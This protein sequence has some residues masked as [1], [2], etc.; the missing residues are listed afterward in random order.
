[1]P[2][3]YNETRIF[4]AATM[5]TLTDRPV[6]AFATWG[7]WIVATGTVRELRSIFPAAEVHDFGNSVVVPGFNDAHQHPTMMAEH[8]LDVDLSPE[9]VCSVEEILARLRSGPVSRARVNG[10]WAAGTTTARAPAATYSRMMSSTAS[11]RNT[12]C[13]SDRSGCIGVC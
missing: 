9:E 7:E 8:L 5:H 1:M 12:R 13:W 3:S 10:C 2:A 4:T 11:V 6:E